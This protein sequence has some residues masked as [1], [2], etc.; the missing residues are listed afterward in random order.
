MSEKVIGSYEEFSKMNLRIE[1]TVKTEPVPQSRNL[2][3]LSID[4]DKGEHPVEI[5]SQI[6]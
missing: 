3:K 4:V 2:I 5:G 6:K 1:K